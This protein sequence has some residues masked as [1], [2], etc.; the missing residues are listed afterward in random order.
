MALAD[1]EA[2]TAIA[3]VAFSVLELTPIATFDSPLFVAPKPITTD[4]AGLL[5]V[6]S[7]VFVV[8][9]PQTTLWLG[10]L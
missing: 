8:A 6:L 10:A 4:F 5:S 3:A 9:S 7:V 2:P 1:A